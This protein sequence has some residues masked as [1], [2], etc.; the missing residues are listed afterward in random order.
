MELSNFG[1]L[2]AIFATCVLLVGLYMFTGHKLGIMTARPAFKHLN[3]D[4]WRNI[5]K[6]TMV[7]SIVIFVVAIVAFVFN[8]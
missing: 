4:Q 1:I 8:I 6:W 7:A 2:M 5:G 3:K